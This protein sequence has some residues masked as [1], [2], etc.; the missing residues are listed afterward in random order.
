MFVE[1]LT[2]PWCPIH[3]YH[4]MTYPLGKNV[5]LIVQPNYKPKRVF[6]MK[7]FLLY[8]MNILVL[9]FVKMNLLK[10]SM[11]LKI[12]LNIGN[13]LVIFHLIY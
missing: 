4:W 12:H 8:L 7:N 13:H 11:Y 10:G 9:I 2:M 5:V 3:M 6:M 1:M